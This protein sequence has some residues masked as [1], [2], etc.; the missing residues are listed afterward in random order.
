MRWGRDRWPK[1]IPRPKA[2]RLTEKERGAIL[3]TMTRAVAASPVLP[4]LGV[5][6]RAQ[7]G[8]FYLER[9]LPKSEQNLVPDVEL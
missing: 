9:K 1:Y 7:R 6:V 3:A 5:Q 4:Y 8:R 2:R